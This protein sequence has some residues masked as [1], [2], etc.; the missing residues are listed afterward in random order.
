M[1]ETTV[2]A[3]S[4]REILDAVRDLELRAAGVEPDDKAFPPRMDP[5]TYIEQRVD[6]Q[7]DGYYR[8]KAKEI[9]RRLGQFRALEFVLASVAAALAAIATFAA[10]GIA[11]WVAVV[12]T[13]A[14]AV[15]AH[16]AATRY[17]YLA[18]TYGATA[19]RLQSL[20]DQWVDLP[21]E[22]R[23]TPSDFV[24]R[25]EDAISVENQA[26]MAKWVADP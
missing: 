6:A 7:I 25:C 3:E 2:L 26:W 19:N 8:P 4:T 16:I 9:A 5:Q 15:T 10:T 18:S 20:R 17:E 22:A 21:P 13:A 23:P 24:H 14:V 11:A 12:T 1:A